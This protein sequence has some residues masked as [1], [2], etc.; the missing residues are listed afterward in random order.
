MAVAGG[1]RDTAEKI[2][3]VLVKL[4]GDNRPTAALRAQFFNCRYGPK[5]SLRSFSLQVRE[6]FSRLQSRTDAGL[7]GGG[8][9]AR[10]Q[11]LFGLRDGPVRQALKLQLRQNPEM[12]FED[13][14]NEALAL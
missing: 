6:L 5:Q 13:V 10:D 2:F 11:F 7:G 3:D 8:N 1:E 12:A 14:R 9:L 4:Y